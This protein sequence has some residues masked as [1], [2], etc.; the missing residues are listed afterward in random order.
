[1]FSKKEAQAIRVEFWTAFGLY[2]KKHSSYFGPG[3]K[4]LN[5]KTGV[6]HI[7]FRLIAEKNQVAI[8]IEIQHKDQ[9]IRA[10]NFDQFAEVRKILD[11][12]LPTKMEHQLHHRNLD[13]QEI[14]RIYASSEAYS[15]YRKDDWGEMFRFLE[16]RLV[17]LDE[18]WY[19][20][21]DLFKEL[22]S[23]S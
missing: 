8:S 6:R 2:M 13:G 16:G 18:F 7:F 20:F 3:H 5:Y 23:L 14:A 1:M 4:W 21:K 22:E 12:M 19:D 17:P 9:G 10:L 15:I 11:E